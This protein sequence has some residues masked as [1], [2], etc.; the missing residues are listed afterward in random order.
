MRTTTTIED[1]DNPTADVGKFNA[2]GIGL[3]G[4]ARISFYDETNGDLEFITCASE[5]C[6]VH[7]QQ[8][9][10]TGGDVGRYTS[11]AVAANG[12]VHVAYYDA[13]NGNLKYIASGSELGAPGITPT[14][15]AIERSLSPGD[16]VLSW[17]ASCGGG[18]EDYSIYEGLLGDWYSHTQLTCTDLGDVPGCLVVGGCVLREEITPGPEGHYYL[19]VPRNAIEEGSYGLGEDGDERPKASSGCVTAQSLEACP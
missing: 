15:L 16:I 19:V 3:D 8:T 18:A 17:E 13:T 10:D 9:L 4:L 11:L 1:M 5:D 12:R 7:S 6:T 2:I 14:T